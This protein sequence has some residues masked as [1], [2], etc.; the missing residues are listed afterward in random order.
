MR[1]VL[2][3]WEWL[4]LIEILSSIMECVYGAEEIPL[5][6]R[7]LAEEM[8]QY[9]PSCLLQYYYSEGY[10]GARRNE[11]SKTWLCYIGDGSW[12]LLRDSHWSIWRWHALNH[13]RSRPFDTFWPLISG[14]LETKPAIQLRCLFG[15]LTPRHRIVLCFLRDPKGSP[16]HLPPR[17]NVF[18]N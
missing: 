2:T 17:F 12:L 8:P 18:Y 5:A 11:A 16:P 3:S 14:D 7:H 10:E 15:S 6:W 1:W 13:Q 4:S 9:L